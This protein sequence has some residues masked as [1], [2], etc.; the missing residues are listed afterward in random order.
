MNEIGLMLTVSGMGGVFVV[1]SLLAFV[2]WVMGRILGGGRSEN[3]DNS[4]NLDY[5]SF[6]ELE[7]SAIAAAI[8]QHE[9]V[10]VPEVRSPENWKR[11][12]RVY[13]TGWL[14]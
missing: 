5:S 12:A 1:L 4:K 11:Y 10:K 8:I 3:K 2:M 14:E 13:A 7:L 6:S 9:S